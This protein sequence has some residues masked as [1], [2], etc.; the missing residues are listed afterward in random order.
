MAVKYRAIEAPPSDGKPA[1]Y[2]QFKCG[3]DQPWLTAVSSYGAIKYTSSEHA[4][5][6]AEVFFKL[7]E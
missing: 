6:G 5:L 3:P 1:W 4:I 7:G 2:G